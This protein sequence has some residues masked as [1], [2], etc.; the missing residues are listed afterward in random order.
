MSNK[1]P[2]WYVPGSVISALWGNV[3]PRL[4]AMVWRHENGDTSG[5]HL[6]W[7]P[8]SEPQ[9]VGT[10]KAYPVD[11]AAR[12][13]FWDALVRNSFT[14][15]DAYRALQ[16][17]LMNRVPRDKAQFS[18]G[19]RASHVV[20][21]Y[22]DPESDR[23]SSRMLP[24]RVIRA[25]AYDF[26]LSS[27]GMDVFIPPN[28]FGE[29]MDYD[30]EKGR[31]AILQMY[32]FRKTGVPPIGLPGVPATGPA[33]DGQDDY[34]IPIPQL[35]APTGAYQIH[36]EWARGEAAN[37]KWWLSGSAYRGIMS[38]LPRIIAYKWYEEAAWPDDAFDSDPRTTRAR[39]YDGADGLKR[40]L[41]ERLETRLPNE[42]KIRVLKDNTRP[43]EANG[44]SAWNERDIMI[45]NRG[46]YIPDPGDAPQ[47]AELIDAIESGRAGNPVFTD[48]A[49]GG[50]H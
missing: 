10:L 48:T 3:M 30:S 27:K 38:E 13:K 4:A 25:D 21:D 31:Q 41:E 20:L 32:K 26:V 7:P 47:S 23:Q 29:D 33:K 12:E 37:V 50:F 2:K 35:S 14:S 44:L 6:E 8:D 24:M 43:P 11:E 40:L 9:E 15:Q 39:F 19:Q 49:T 46:L 17:S 42:L 1:M 5:T 18:E 28:P 34:L 45:T 36:E 16:P 22:F